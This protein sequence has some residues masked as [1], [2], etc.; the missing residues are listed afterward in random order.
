MAMTTDD[1]KEYRINLRINEEMNKKLNERSSK[2]GVSISEY[3]RNLINDAFT[4]NEED[5]A[6]DKLTKGMR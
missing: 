4:G 2:Q 3:V 6:L 1:P 5:S